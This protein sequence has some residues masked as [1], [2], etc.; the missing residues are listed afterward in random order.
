[1]SRFLL[2]IAEPLLYRNPDLTRGLSNGQGPAFFELRGFARQIIN[3]P[4]FA[5]MVCNLK[6]A[7]LEVEWGMARPPGVFNEHCDAAD[8]DR[9]CAIQTDTE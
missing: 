3:R 1:M 9:L 8:V 5:P 7:S 2:A 6:I 4:R